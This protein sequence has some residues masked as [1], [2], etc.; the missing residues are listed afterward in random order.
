MLTN[1]RV[2]IEPLFTV[3][4]IGPLFELYFSYRHTFI[5]NEWETDLTRSLQKIFYF[6][7]DFEHSFQE[8]FLF[9]ICRVCLYVSMRR[10]L[11]KPYNLSLGDS[12]HSTKGM[13]CVLQE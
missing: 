6:I 8:V 2:M 12:I 13:N 5:N 9:F 11:N 1:A 3:E 4:I 7:S 10:I